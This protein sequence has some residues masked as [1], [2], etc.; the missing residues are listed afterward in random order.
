MTLTQREK[1]RV[2]R[3]RTSEKAVRSKEHKSPASG[4]AE[5]KRKV[6]YDDENMKMS[7]LKVQGRMEHNAFL[8]LPSILISD[9][10]RRKGDTN[11][12]RYIKAFLILSFYSLSFC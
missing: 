10:T 5:I 4:S 3:T 12:F 9:I 6:C 7:M 1:G 11:I 8:Y 2:T